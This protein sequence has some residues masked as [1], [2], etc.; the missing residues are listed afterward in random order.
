MSA[1]NSITIAEKASNM[2]MLSA[3]VGIGVFC[4]LLIVLTYEGTL[5]RVKLLKAAALEAAVFQV[6]P[7]TVKTQA[8]LLNPD[9]TFSAVEGKQPEGQVVFAGYNQQDE[10]IGVAIEASGQG[11]ADVIRVLYGYSPEKEQIIGFFVLESKETPGLGDKIEKDAGFLANF[12]ALEVSLGSEGQVE[13]PIVTVKQGTKEQAWEIDGITGATISARAIGNILGQS[14]Q[15]M[16]YIIKK[17]R[18]AFNLANNER[19]Q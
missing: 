12:N 5:P 4:A 9:N 13:N 7:G 14:T 11:Y 10:L 15:E 6:L 8:F 18:E 16:A 2:K 19:I 1:T 17:N 3:M